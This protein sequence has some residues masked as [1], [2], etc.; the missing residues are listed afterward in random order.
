MD[1][2]GGWSQA[3]PLIAGVGGGVASA[4]SPYAAQGI[5]TGIGVSN[6]MLQQQEYWRRKQQEKRQRE[7]LDR[8]LASGSGTGAVLKSGD[9]A[10]MPHGVAVANAEAEDAQAKFEAARVAEGMFGL[11]G[12]TG[13]V[14]GSI[15][16]AM[17][18]GVDTMGQH[19]G[20]LSDRAEFYKAAV[21]EMPQQQ[22]LSPA[23]IAMIQTMAESNPGDATMMA[24]RAKE[25]N[26]AA[27]NRAKMDWMS[28]MNMVDRMALQDQLMRG[29]S[30]MD[31]QERLDALGE[32]SRL[33]RE[34]VE[35][36]AHIGVTAGADRIRLNP[37]TGE[38][39]VAYKGER[40]G[41][42]DD[43]IIPGTDQVGVFSLDK[44][45]WLRDAD[46]NIL[47]SG[48]KRNSDPTS[49]R[50]TLTKSSVGKIR[51]EE[52]VSEYTPYEIAMALAD[53]MSAK[54][55]AGRTVDDQVA[56]EREDQIQRLRRLYK[57]AKAKQAERGER[58]DGRLAQ[59]DTIM[60]VL[61]GSQETSPVET[62]GGGTHRWTIGPDGEPRLVE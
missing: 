52:I 8:L 25:A 6:T 15:G 22:G 40:A 34:E 37:D 59:F 20:G 62:G 56:F 49:T 32:A 39:E 30:A 5:R 48:T 45:E 18:P 42:Y 47:L 28:E 33:N 11:M 58:P 54:A 27:L 23:T 24:F 2:E 3:L 43:I 7:M 60:S 46:G 41:K 13:G 51:D 16:R 1:G 14:T 9:Q 36:R 57:E 4:Y 26:K 31:Q 17:S 19:A 50:V 35:H 44:E 55:S 21:P 38:Y 61:F 53:V 12:A 10:I 29:R